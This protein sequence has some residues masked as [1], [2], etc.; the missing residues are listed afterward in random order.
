MQANAASVLNESSQPPTPGPLKAV[1]VGSGVEA[2]FRGPDSATELAARRLAQ[3]LSLPHRHISDPRAPHGPLGQLQASAEGCLA[4]L[5]LDPGQSLEDGGS[6]AEALGAWRQPTLLIIRGQQLPSGA[7]AATIA[8]LRH[9]R[10]PILGVLQW[11]G[12]W[13]P[14][15]RRRD[16]LPWLGRLEESALAE[17]DGWARPVADLLL[18]RWALLDSL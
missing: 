18:R 9:W 11:G 10:V 16:G 3:S 8:L 2:S 15:R 4:S 5:P 7:A 6:W 1:V 13:S 14:E 17:E 12:S